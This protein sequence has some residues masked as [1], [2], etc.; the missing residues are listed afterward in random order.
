[1]E[2]RHALRTTGAIREFTSKD[3]SDDDI[4]TI[5]DDAR[6]APSGGNRQ[7][8]HVVVV[9]DPERKRAIRD[10]YLDA[11]HDYVAHLLGGLTPFSPLATSADREQAQ[12]LRDAAVARSQPDGFA[13]TFDRSPVLLVLLADLGALAAVD[14]DL[15]RYTFAGGGSIYTAS[16][17]AKASIPLI[18]RRIEDYRFRDTD[19]RLVTMAGLRG[20]P[21]VVQFIYTG[22]FQVCERCAPSTRPATSSGPPGTKG[23]TSRTG[24][25]G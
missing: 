20:R 10:I 2:L 14:R 7:A 1:M 18:G 24:L 15:H 25:D 4:R 21:L 3:V 13:E 9:K 8:W 6:F 16:H 23:T 17:A 22:C 12:A 11:W 5:L 19:G